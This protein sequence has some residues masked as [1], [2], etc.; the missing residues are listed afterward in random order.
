MVLTTSRREA[1][2]AKYNVLLLFG[3]NLRDFS[4]AFRPP[5]LDKNASTGRLPQGDPGKAGTG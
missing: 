2:A 4:E 3:G 5:T 1:V